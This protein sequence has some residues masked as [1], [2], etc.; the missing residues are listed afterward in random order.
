MRRGYERGGEK[1]KMRLSCAVESGE[2][3]SFLLFLSFVCSSREVG[4]R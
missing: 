1:K 3:F 2:F 4:G